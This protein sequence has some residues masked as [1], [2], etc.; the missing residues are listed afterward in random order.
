MTQSTE[1]PSQIGKTDANKDKTSSN[2]Q[3]PIKQII[4]VIQKSPVKNSP[5]EKSGVW[6]DI[7]KSQERYEALL[8]SHMKV[9]KDKE[10]IIDSLESKL[11][12]AKEN[13]AEIM[14]KFEEQDHKKNSDIKNLQN[15]IENL[16][17]DKNEFED[18]IKN[19]EEEIE[20]LNGKIL[21][22]EELN[23]KNDDINNVYERE[24][25]NFLNKIK[26]LETENNRLDDKLQQAL[27]RENLY[28][29]GRVDNDQIAEG[30]LL[31]SKE[32]E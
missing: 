8:D 20:E 19:K 3:V 5:G 10:R 12:L 7:E 27:R 22:Q 14:E 25:T 13:Q 30:A 32:Q 23:E 15:L 29:S 2:T 1:M 26:D 28:L 6:F 9:I 31:M 11:K 16:N 18:I 24:R 17:K 21:L 4:E